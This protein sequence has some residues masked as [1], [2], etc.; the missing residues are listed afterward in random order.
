M[1][2]GRR[3]LTNIPQLTRRAW[4]DV[5][6]ELER[7]LR[8]LWESESNGVPAGFGNIV[9][10]PIVPGDAGSEG[11]GNTSGWA[12]ADH[13]HPVATGTPS[14][15]DNALGEGTSSAIPRL[16]HKH[17]RD[18]RV[19]EDGADKGTRNAVNF[20]HGLDATDEPGNDRVTVAVDE[21][22]LDHGLLSGLL[23]D[24]HPL[25][26]RKHGFE[27]SSSGAPLQTISY[28]PG[29]RKITITPTGATFRFWIDG[30][31]FVKTGAQV[32]G[33]HST[34]TGSQYFYYDATGTLQVSIGVWS[35]RDRTVTPVA[36]V[37][38]NN[39]IA[40]GVCFYE[41]H[42]A[43][44]QLE[45]HFY[46]H[47]SVGCR[48]ISGIDLTG[49]TPLTDTD[50]AVTYAIGDGVIADEDIRFATAAVADGGPYV[51]FYRSTITGEWVWTTTDTFPF[52]VGATPFPQRNDINAGGAGVWG[53]TEV[54]D[55]V[56]RY[57]NYF[58]CATTAVV[59]ASASTFL[60]PGQTDHAT[61]LS[62]RAETIQSM[63]LG[64]F[65]F[66]EVA[67]I[68]RITL[69]CRTI[70]GGT[71][72]C[73]IEE[74]ASIKNQTVTV[75]GGGGGVTDHGA[76]TGLLDDDHTQ[77][78]LRSE[79]GSASG[80]AG[81]DA[82]SVVSQPVKLYRQGLDAAVPALAEGELYWA[83]DTDTLYVGT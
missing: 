73:R 57:V 23:D 13:E 58:L 15:L 18:V 56:G 61:L 7:F 45:N 76:L 63:S 49:W 59:P 55:A 12:A 47:F 67:P 71:N 78:Q 72:N 39:T 2:L 48:Y 24:D 21:S 4:E 6:P 79:K 68:W 53:L 28:D 14:L 9:P 29:T 34:T 80:Y 10:P 60:I 35:I 54:G 50:A 46:L 3:L 44:R 41:C 17:K 37:Y 30:V 70:L 75:T 38:W 16:D 66:V 62:A 19:K 40:D 52:K 20:T 42:T 69:F 36:I 77:Y 33:A 81:L 31:Q 5:A 22:E 64:S 51:I 27:V 83:T 82:S 32:S 25:Y 65:P 8:R 1:S 26:Q 11:T 43:D 74:I